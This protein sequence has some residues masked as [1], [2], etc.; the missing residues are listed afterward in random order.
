MRVECEAAVGGNVEGGE[1]GIEVRLVSTT[2]ALAS[3]E[4]HKREAH[5]AGT[6]QGADYGIHWATSK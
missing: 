2:S 6:R 5:L 4:R 3:C 1:G